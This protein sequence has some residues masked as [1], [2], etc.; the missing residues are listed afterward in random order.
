M[1]LIDI[2]G[3]DCVLNGSIKLSILYLLLNS[4]LVFVFP[5][6]FFVRYVP[7]VQDVASIFPSHGLGRD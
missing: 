1:K 4:P 6:N 5:N 3:D 2:G 7:K